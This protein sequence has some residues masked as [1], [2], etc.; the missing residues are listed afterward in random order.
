MDESGPLGTTYALRKALQGSMFL[1]SRDVAAKEL[2]AAYEVAQRL[3]AR[4]L[5]EAIA[6]LACRAGLALPDTQPERNR[7]RAALLPGVG[8][9]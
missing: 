1:P 4:P 8:C 9:R 5:G 3:G 7:H 2:L 6:D